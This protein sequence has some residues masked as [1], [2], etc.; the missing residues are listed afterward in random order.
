MEAD[1]ICS[2][3]VGYHLWGPM[4]VLQD[5][6]FAVMKCEYWPGGERFP[7]IGIESKIYFIMGER[8]PWNR[9]F[10]DISFPRIR[11][12]QAILSGLSLPLRRF[13]IGQACSSMLAP[14]DAYGQRKAARFTFLH[15]SFEVLNAGIRPG[16]IGVSCAW[17]CLAM[18]SGQDL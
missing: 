14:Q 11:L 3:F 15:Q 9:G 16:N 4:R 18:I 2:P 10:Q 17:S 12:E 5:T 8:F 13:P 1:N 6:D 7:R